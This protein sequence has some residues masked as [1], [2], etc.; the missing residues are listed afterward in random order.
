MYQHRHL[1]AHHKIPSS[2]VRRTTGVP[3]LMHVLLLFSAV[4][5]GVPAPARAFPR[6][7]APH[8]I[9]KAGSRNPRMWIESLPH[10]ACDDRQI[11]TLFDAYRRTSFCNSIPILDLHITLPSCFLPLSLMSY[12]VPANVHVSSHPCLRAKLSQLRA[13]TT[14]SRETKQL[15]HD[16]TLLVGSEA[17]AHSLTVQQTGTVRLRYQSPE[18]N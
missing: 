2:D 16:I 1:N 15:V 3:V 10:V 14:T 17:L 9:D 5:R 7:S 13:S 4:C 18:P 12:P 6:V 11:S 8:V